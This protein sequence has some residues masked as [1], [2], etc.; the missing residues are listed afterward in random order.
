[1]NDAKQCSP[2]LNFM[3]IGAEM[4][5]YSAPKLKISNFGRKFV[6]QGN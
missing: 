6:P 3:F 1:M 5:E 4:W 2:M